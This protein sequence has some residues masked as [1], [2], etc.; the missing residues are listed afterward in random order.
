MPPFT[1][2][3]RAPS[4][5]PAVRHSLPEQAGANGRAEFSPCGHY[6]WWLLRLWEPEAPRLLFLGLNP[7]RADGRRD[8]PT[9]RRLIGFARAWGYGGLEVLNLFGRIS[10][11]PAALR[12]CSDPVGNHCDA[13]IRRRLRRV[14]REEGGQPGL[15]LGWGNGGSWR[16]R[17]RAVL[18]LLA[19]QGCRPHCLGLTAVGQPRHPLYQPRTGRLQPFTPSWGNIH[20]PIAAASPCPA[21]PVATPST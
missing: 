21:F 12:R 20:D 9:L 19:A 6:R 16:G 10:A 3:T 7:S 1:I 5:C 18:G 2:S 15:W 4:R 8:D 14:C 11:S 17:D 13:W